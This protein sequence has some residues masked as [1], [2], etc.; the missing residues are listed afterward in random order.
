MSA[1]GDAQF[2][3]SGLRKTPQATTAAASTTALT[4]IDWGRAKDLLDTSTGAINAK[5]E[6]ECKQA[7]TLLWDA[8]QK[9]FAMP[10]KDRNAFVDRY[11]QGTR[12]ATPELDAIA[13][14]IRGLWDAA[15]KAYQKEKGTDEVVPVEHY[16]SRGYMGARGAEASAFQ[17][18]WEG[19][20]GKGPGS[21]GFG[22][23]P[24]PLMERSLDSMAE[25]RRLRAQYLKD[26]EA[27][28]ARGDTAGFQDAMKKANW[29]KPTSDNPV[30]MQLQRY[31]AFTDYLRDLRIF[32]FAKEHGYLKR[33]M[34]SRGVGSRRTAPNGAISPLF[35]IY[36]P[37][38]IRVPEH[39]DADMYVGLEKYCQSM[40][41]DHEQA[42]SVGKGILGYYQPG[43]DKIATRF[44]TGIGA[45]T[46]EIGH[47][48]DEH[49]NLRRD[50]MADPAAKKEL[51]RLADWR[52]SSL[53]WKPSGDFL[54]YIKYPSEMVANAFHA[55]MVS[56]QRMEAEAPHC[57][58]IV[59][60]T[61][62][63]DPMFQPLLDVKPGTSF[64]SVPRDVPVFG[65]RIGGYWQLP[66][67]LAGSVERFGS[68]SIYAK[69]N[70]GGLAGKAG[71]AAL[72]GTQW[73]TSKMM[74]SALSLSGYH[75]LQ[76]TLFSI[77]KDA[78]DIPSK[79]TGGDL[80][81]AGKAAARLLT[82][83]LQI[84]KR[85]AAGEQWRK[86][87]AAGADRCGDR[88]LASWQ[89]AFCLRS[90]CRSPGGPLWT[91]RRSCK[92]PT[93]RPST[94]SDIKSPAP[95]MG[96]G[97]CRSLRRRSQCATPAT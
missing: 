93:S 46:H 25:G 67:A 4:P 18:F 69:L 28:K 11:E 92:T 44:F 88:T 39:V 61:L 13:G 54:R 63:A 51:E 36:L 96:C 76:T 27:A 19:L 68:E 94:G 33:S 52:T 42:A 80:V 59:R 40:G 43:T 26:A 41:I 48:V 29:L 85:L 77:A 34:G 24:S 10:E 37:P 75:A 82:E 90:R 79:L 60:D 35:T 58:Q 30:E 16:F 97:R 65:R 53:P 73:A 50:L 3:K 12:Q 55:F 66:D 81:G 23:K 14:Q 5:K 49:S 95:G 31:D 87:L 47:F 9:F 57:Y 21:Q 64:Y 74:Q 32:N 62:A 72:Q 45:Q 38:T 56:P 7:D 83:P 17:T 22:R 91:R 2:A 8:R 71:A 78:A 15:W 84:V 20:T 89:G 1:A 6:A 70:R 86:D